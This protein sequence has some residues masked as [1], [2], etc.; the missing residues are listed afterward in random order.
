MS[1]SKLVH[2]AALSLA[3]ASGAIAEDVVPAATEPPP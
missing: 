2:T 3:L 1:L